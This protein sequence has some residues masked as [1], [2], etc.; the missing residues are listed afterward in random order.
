VTG[1]ASER[2]RAEDPRGMMETPRDGRREISLIWLARLRWLA[3][4]GQVG[5]LV[6][7]R[8]VLSAQVPVAPFLAVVLVTALSNLAVRAFL[9][10]GRTPAAGLPGALL[11]LDTLSLT[12]LLMLSG[13]PSNPFST[14]YLVHVT[15]AAV[16]LGARWAW[17]L[18][19]LAVAC[20]ASLFFWYV[21]IPELE[22][23]GHR[24]PAGAGLHLNHFQT[25]WVALSVSA[26]LTVLFVVRLA[27]ALEKRNEEVARMR[28]RALKAERLAVVTT[29]AAGAAHELG[30]PLGTIAV[31]ASELER[32]LRES[33]APDLPA[34]VGDARLICAEVERCRADHDR[35]A[36]EGGE[37]TGEDVSPIRAGDV[38]SDA[39][40][41]LPEADARRVVFE[42]RAPSARIVAPQ[43]A[44]SR[45][46]RDVLRNALEASPPGASVGLQ[47]EAEPGS[48]RIMTLDEGAGIS[49]EALGR[50]GEPFFSTKSPG[51][52]LG[53]GLFLARGL[54]ESLGGRLTVERRARAGTAVTL[55][56]PAAEGA[57]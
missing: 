40:A 38:A 22:H 18:T 6:F 33:K 51:Q 10:S 15:L 25:M 57:A 53:L 23:M 21:P 50:V 35:I 32:V 46:L 9:A 37:I 20:Y 54:C 1:A 34:L 27:G 11:T 24:M 4:L 45:T 44:L 12:G 14:L 47:I 16:V 8:Q 55:E 5:A 19:G 28:E 43:K 31:A 52:G 49:P 48:V 13:G 7:A 2:M 41:S 29:L 36:S 39:L 17:I 3:V 30:T 42:D 56:L 26:F